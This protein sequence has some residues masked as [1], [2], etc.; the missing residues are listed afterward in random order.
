MNPQAQREKLMRFLAKLPVEALNPLS[1]KQIDLFLSVHEIGAAQGLVLGEMGGICE[2]V[3]RVLSGEDSPSN[4]AA[5]ISQDKNIEE[6]NRPKIPAIAQEI[7]RQIF[8]PVLPILKQAGLPVKEG[9]VAPAPAAPRHVSLIGQ[10]RPI[11]PMGPA[12]QPPRAAPFIK[13]DRGGE[14]SVSVP[15]Q[16]VQ[17]PRQFSVSLDE[18]HLRALLRI[19]AGTNYT[20]ERLREAFEDLPEGLKRAIVSVDTANAV[21]EIAKKFLLHIDQMAALASETGLVLLGL[22]HPKDFVKNLASRLRISEARALEIAREV[23]AQ[24]LVKVREALRGLHESP[25]AKGVPTSEAGRVVTPSASADL[26]TSL[27][28]EDITPALEDS[29]T[30]FGKGE[31]PRAQTPYSA[32]WKTGD[33]QP[34]REE[35]LRGI[36][37]PTSAPEVTRKEI[38][39]PTGWRKPVAE[40]TPMPPTPASKPPPASTT[41]HSPPRA[42]GE[43]PADSIEQKLAGPMGSKPETRRY[44]IDPYR[45]PPE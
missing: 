41:P 33:E 25:L 17:V 32:Q 39:G 38:V 28:R 40:A 12:G 22:T 45:E 24:I 43:E 18:R 29:G 10:I 37:Q 34:T 35:V 1:E 6:D 31:L 2:G 36:E 7:Q 8:D 9:R 23:S 19:A 20:E 27:I 26:G 11:G 15:R 3:R 30:P 5:F 16:D 13:G 4:L 44:T 14:S 21:Q 42:G